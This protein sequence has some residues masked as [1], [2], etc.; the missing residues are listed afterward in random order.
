[1]LIIP[2]ETKRPSE[3]IADWLVLVGRSWDYSQHFDLQFFFVEGLQFLLQRDNLLLGLDQLL[4]A[5]DHD[6]EVLVGLELR[7]YD[8]LQESQHIL[9]VSAKFGCLD[10]DDFDRLNQV[11]RLGAKL[12]DEVVQCEIVLLIYILN[13]DEVV[14]PKMGYQLFEC[15]CCLLEVDAK[16]L[17]VLDQILNLFIAEHELLL[18]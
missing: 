17:Q 3:N 2:F 11:V 4:L 6:I 16:L 13:F 9:I 12:R 10:F 5:L 7:H 14:H 1:M 15:R 18:F 8:S